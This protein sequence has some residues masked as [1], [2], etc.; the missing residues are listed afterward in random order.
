MII[1]MP[2]TKIRVNNSVEGELFEHY[3][4]KIKT[5]KEPIRDVSPIIYDERKNSINPDC[6][7]RTDK[8]DF[9]LE[10]MSKKTDL[11][12]NLRSELKKPP[13]N[14]TPITPIQEVTE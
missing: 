8:W 7:I 4:K 10:A 11:V 5:S 14:Q 12:L 3:I 2:K 1:K 9:A 13:T 6:D